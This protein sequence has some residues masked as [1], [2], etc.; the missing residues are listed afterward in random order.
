MFSVVIPCYNNDV[1]LGRVLAGFAVQETSAP[2]ELILVDNN[3]FAEDINAV[4]LRYVE[5]LPLYLVRQAQ[6]PHPRAT[7]RARNVGL[8]LAS[9]DWVINVDS[10]C[11][12]APNFVEGYFRA[13]ERD[14]GANALYVG[15]RKF[16][17]GREITEEDILSGNADVTTL[18]QVESPSNYHKVVDHRLPDIEEL[19]TS[20]HPWAYIHSGNIAYQKNSA[21]RIGGYDIAFD[22]VWGYEDIDFAHR[23]INVDGAKPVYLQGIENYHQ[24]CGEA[25]KRDN[26]MKKSDNRNWKIICERIEGFEEFKREQYQRVNPDIEV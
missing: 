19:G 11:I 14:G 10:D 18:K 20:P 8:S 5:K 25:G 2:Y 22:G 17:D 15:L 6:L 21:L 13:I 7:A 4:Y 9:Y 24:D 12:P 1:I 3:G 26:R 23:L 16:I